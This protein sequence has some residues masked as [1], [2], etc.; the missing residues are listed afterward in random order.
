[1][2]PAVTVTFPFRFREADTIAIIQN[3]ATKVGVGVLQ[4][5]VNHLKESSSLSAVWDGVFDSLEPRVVSSVSI[6]GIDRP[7]S[8]DAQ[9]PRPEMTLKLLLNDADEPTE[10]IAR[11]E[12]LE[13]FARF[14]E[15]YRAQLNY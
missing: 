7:H 9:I 13:A 3:I 6:F 10:R 4:S 14:A 8:D 15:L 1:M 12:F 5:T 11:Q 2:F